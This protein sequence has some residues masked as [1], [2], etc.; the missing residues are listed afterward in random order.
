MATYQEI[1]TKQARRRRDYVEL[2]ECRVF[3]KNIRD[4]IRAGKAPNLIHFYHNANEGKENE[5][6][7][8]IGLLPGLADYTFVYWKT[9]KVFSGAVC[10]GTELYPTIAYIEFKASGKRLSPE[11]EAFNQR[12]VQ[13]MGFRSCWRIPRGRR[14]TGLFNRGRLKHEAQERKNPPR[15]PQ[16]RFTGRQWATSDRCATRPCSR[17]TGRIGR[18]QNARQSHPMLARGR[19]S[20]LQVQRENRQQHRDHAAGRN[21]EGS[22]MTF[23]YCMAFVIGFP[24]VVLLAVVSVIIGGDL[25]NHR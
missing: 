17:R 10:V 6:L 9:I 19:V 11:Q 23:I 5:K 13:H 7:V 21:D 14:L 8:N 22:M 18:T 2:K 12:C 15:A 25:D 3:T 1:M 24:F 16:H 20:V 4:T